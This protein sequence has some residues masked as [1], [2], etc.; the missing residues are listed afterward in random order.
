MRFFLA[1][2]WR[3]ANQNF[4]LRHKSH[5]IKENVHGLGWSS[6]SST[7]KSLGSTELVVVSMLRLGSDVDGPAITAEISWPELATFS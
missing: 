1:E 6:I 2:T 7:S 4:F 3:K 5:I